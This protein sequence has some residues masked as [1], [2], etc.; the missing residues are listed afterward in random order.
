MSSSVLSRV[1]PSL[2]LAHLKRGVLDLQY[3]S[4]PNTPWNSLP[5][6]LKL[7]TIGTTNWESVRHHFQKIMF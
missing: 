5:K 7:A 2:E 3:S 1:N 4:F 6:E